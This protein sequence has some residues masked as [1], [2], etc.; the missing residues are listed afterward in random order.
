MG[1]AYETLSDPQKRENYDS[2]RDLQDPEDM[3]GGAG[4]GGMGGMNIDPSKSLLGVLSIGPQTN[5]ICCRC[6]VQHD[7]RH[8]RRRWQL[9]IWWWCTRRV[10]GQ[11]QA[12]GRPAAAGFPEWFQFLGWVWGLKKGG[13]GRAGLMLL[14]SLLVLSLWCCF[15]FLLCN[16]V[17]HL[18]FLSLCAVKS[19]SGFYQLRRGRVCIFD[20]VIAIW[21]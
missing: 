7:G 5:V 19:F 2:G 17:F 4:M 20:R 16:A 15:F 18:L 3:F 9:L 10:P 8:G 13:L 14:F 1:E 12:E 21:P 6:L 11:Q